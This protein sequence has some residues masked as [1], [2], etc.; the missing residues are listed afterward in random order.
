MDVEAFTLTY[1]T[2]E[3]VKIKFFASYLLAYEWVVS[4]VEVITGD[5]TITKSR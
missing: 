2:A 3:G 5:Y 4:N 1:E